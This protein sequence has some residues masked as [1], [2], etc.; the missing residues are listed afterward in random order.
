MKKRAKEKRKEKLANGIKCEHEHVIERV[1]NRVCPR[2]NQLILFYIPY[3]TLIDGD[4]Y[5]HKCA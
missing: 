2:R 4:F 1:T 5:H 3:K